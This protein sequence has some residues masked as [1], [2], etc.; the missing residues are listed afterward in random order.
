[1]SGEIVCLTGGVG[2]AKLVLGLDRVLAPGG[3]VLL[4]AWL[5]RLRQLSGAVAPANLRKHFEQAREAA[6]IET[7]PNNALRHSYGSYHLKHFGNDALTRL[8]MGHWRDSTVLFA[9]YRRAVT[10]RNAERYW[11]IRPTERAAKIVPMHR[12]KSP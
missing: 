5:L 11:N 2:G 12:L 10:R 6:G 1:M 7:W 3:R 4:A 9:H 8:Q